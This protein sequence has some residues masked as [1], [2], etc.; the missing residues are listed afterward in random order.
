[1]DIS[2]DMRLGGQNFADVN[3]SYTLELF[4]DDPGDDPLDHWNIDWGD[5]TTSTAPG[6]ATTATHVYTALADS[7]TIAASAV[8]KPIPAS[9]GPTPPPPATPS[10]TISA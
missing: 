6:S 4:H 7:R 10:I 3:R 9:S 5:G 2:P 1:V 8:E